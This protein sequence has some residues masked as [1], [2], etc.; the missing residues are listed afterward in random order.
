MKGTKINGSVF[1]ILQ[2][3][4]DFNNILI[5]FLESLL[6]YLKTYSLFFQQDVL[7]DHTANN[8][9]HCW[10]SVYVDWHTS[11]E[12]SLTFARSKAMS[13]ICTSTC[14]ACWRTKYTVTILSLQTTCQKS[15]GSNAF[16]LT[17]KSWTWSE[18]HVRCVSCLQAGLNLF[19]KP[20]T[21]WNR[22]NYILWTPIHTTLEKWHKPY[23]LSPWESIWE[24]RKSI[25]G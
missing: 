25:V 9:V 6:M 10:E 4:I 20:N 18:S 13:S 22:V 24:E 14:G 7:S 19:C 23:S 8:S 2:S 17:N 1:L 3:R 21:S 16:N 15:S 5:S 11:S 12:C